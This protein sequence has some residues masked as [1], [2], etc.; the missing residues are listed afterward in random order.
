MS[1]SRSRSRGSTTTG[2]LYRTSYNPDGTVY[3]PRTAVGWGSEENTEVMSDNNNGPFRLRSKQ[4]EVVLSDCTLVRISTH[5][6][7][8]NGALGPDPDF[9]RAVFDGSLAVLLP[10]LAEWFDVESQLAYAKSDSL[11]EAYAK[12]NKSPLLGGEIIGSLGKT[13]TMMRKPF[14]GAVDLLA[15]MAK[16]KKKYSGKS[17]AS[18]RKAISNTWLEY[19]YGWKPLIMDI[20]TG[21]REAQNS[22][23]RAFQERAVA[24]HTIKIS[25]EEIADGGGTVAGWYPVSCSRHLKI[26]ATASAGVVFSVRNRKGADLAVK[27]AGL[28]SRSVP[29]TLWEM[30]PYSFVVDWF[31]GV[32]PWLQAIVPDPDA[33]VI[34]TWVTSTVKTRMTISNVK[35]EI[36]VGDP[37]RTLTLY[38]GDGSRETLSYVRK[39]DAR[40]PILP[41]FKGNP[42]SLLHATDG[43]ALMAQRI[44]SGLKEFGKGR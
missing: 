22:S 15:R 23:V 27:T 31:V 11:I 20:Q 35:V 12:M 2:V 33:N 6:P 9:G 41:Q 16:S 38:G 13:L 43:L 10:S 17:A 4:G 19:R 42:L 1:T 28:D 29:A 26:D 7:T 36:Y 8:L 32:G 34:G 30:I 14:S 39:T 3:V 24:R 18:V 40:L 25:E 37:P 5:A 21:I 44:T